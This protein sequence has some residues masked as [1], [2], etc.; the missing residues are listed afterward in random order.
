MAKLQRVDKRGSLCEKRERV[1][2]P[3]ER[4]ALARVGRPS[5]RNRR[6]DESSAFLSFCLH[7]G[8]EGNGRKEKEG[9]TV[10][11]IHNCVD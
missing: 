2:G 6:H 3:L 9:D 10:D 8:H 1:S 5:V 4:A 7:V 11:H